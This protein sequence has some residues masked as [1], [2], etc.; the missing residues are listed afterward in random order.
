MKPSKKVNSLCERD[1]LSDMR[2][3]EEFLL[4][5][6]IEMLCEGGSKFF[7]DHILQGLAQT[8]EDLRS[9][10]AELK[11]GGTTKAIEVADDE[12]VRVRKN[13]A[14]RLKQLKKE[15]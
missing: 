3:A 5:R 10:E 13:F 7:C 14:G 6:Y 8:A 9:V 4:R 1:A 2:A 15:N 11:V 12:V